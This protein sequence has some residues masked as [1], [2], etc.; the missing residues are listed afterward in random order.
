MQLQ[1]DGDLQ[2]APGETVTVAVTAVNTHYLAI[3]G[4]LLNADW[5]IA[6]PLQAEFN[7]RLILFKQKLKS[8]RNES[9]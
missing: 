4:D 1:P 7:L 5:V 9:I 2:I 8:T 3:F 6:Q